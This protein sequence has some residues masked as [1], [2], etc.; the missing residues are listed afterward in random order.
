MPYAEAM[1]KYGSDKPDLRFD[2]PHVD[3]TDLVL[4]HGGGGVPFWVEIADK[5]KSG[6]LR[7][8]MRPEIVKAIVI[9]AAANLSRP[10]RGA[11]E[12]PARHQGLPR[13]RAREDRGG[14]LVDAVAARQER[15]RPSPRAAIN[16]ACGAKPGD[17]VFFQFGKETSSTR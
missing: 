3:L 4:E 15:S 11:G 13:P 16:E 1:T 12:G 6:A 9:P 8:D 17:V 7:A 14:R 2:L 5:Y 10:S